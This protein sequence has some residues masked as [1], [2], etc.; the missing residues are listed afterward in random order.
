MLLKLERE[1]IDG[2]R[3]QTE[4]PQPASK[5][6]DDDAPTVFPV[7]DHTHPNQSAVH[8]SATIDENGMDGDRFAGWFASTLHDVEGPAVLAMWAGRIAL[9]E[10]MAAAN[11]HKVV[12][13][14][15]PRPPA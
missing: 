7:S 5:R 3:D 9:Q 2:F 13:D 4:Q 10:V 8:L 11:K 14:V 1:H 15:K 6:R 12:I